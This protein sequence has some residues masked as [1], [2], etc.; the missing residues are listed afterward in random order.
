[1]HGVNLGE[2]L[3]LRAVHV[4]AHAGHATLQSGVQHHGHAVGGP[5]HHHRHALGLDHEVPD[6]LGKSEKEQR[7]TYVIRNE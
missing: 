4:S 7:F 3:F 2:F 6:V 5:Y 1:M